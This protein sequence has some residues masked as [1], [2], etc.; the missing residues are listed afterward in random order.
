MQSKFT[1][2]VRIT[3]L[4]MMKMMNLRP[5]Q[6]VSIMGA[7]GQ[8]LGTTSAG[9][10]II[11]WQSEGKKFGQGGNSPKTDAINNGRLR[12]YARSYGAK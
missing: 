9:T 2:T 12:K 8:Y 5:G 10:D 1:S 11:R 7:R 4:E 6:W 3:S